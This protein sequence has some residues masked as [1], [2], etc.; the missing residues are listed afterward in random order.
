[1]PEGRVVAPRAWNPYVSLRSGEISLTDTPGGGRQETVSTGDLGPVAEWWRPSEGA[2]GARGTVL[3]LLCPQEC[4][5]NP[6]RRGKCRYRINHDGALHAASYGRVSAHGL[7]PIE[8][9]PLYHFMPGTHIFSVGS[10]GCNLACGFC[11]NWQI[12]QNEAQTQYLPPPDA[13]RLA[14]VSTGHGHSSVGLA[15]TYSEP[16]V[17]WEYVRDT[18]QLVR[19][20]GLVNVLVTN[21]YVAEAPL[22]ELLPLI[23][24]M[25]VDVKGF[26]EDFY[27]KTCRGH[28]RPALRTV[29]MAHAAGTHLEVTTLL[30]PGLND[31]PEEVERL[32]RW[33]AKISPAI[34]LHFSRYFPNYLMREPGPTPAATLKRARDIARQHLQYVYV[35]NAFDAEAADTTCPGCGE[36]VITRDGFSVLLDSLKDGACASCGYRI[37]GHARV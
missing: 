23:D 33:L 18:A 36:T 5:I 34:P 31:D 28:L 20:K 2:E 8:K 37:L 21:G 25:N 4:H 22:A 6:G 14:G 11:Q 16:L 35:G 15:Y 27:L 29:E 26:T 24:A 3:C 30:I 17:W 12:S 9:K 32:S 7:D 13:A 19:E 1:M 10:V